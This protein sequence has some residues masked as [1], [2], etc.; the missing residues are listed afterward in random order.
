MKHWSFYVD[1]D[2]DNRKDQQRQSLA[3]LAVVT[4]WE[5]KLHVF[6]IKATQAFEKAF[7]WVYICQPASK[8]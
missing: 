6:I 8:T 3:K 4:Y 2:L 5:A 7:T 1:I